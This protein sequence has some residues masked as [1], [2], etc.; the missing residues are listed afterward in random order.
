MTNPIGGSN[1]VNR[2]G[3]VCALAA[4]A[5]VVALGSAACDKKDWPIQGEGAPGI[6][7]A[8]LN[9]LV[10]KYLADN[11]M[12][13]ATVAVTRAGRLVWSK[14]YGW[15]NENERLRMQ[16]WHRSRI[17]STSKFI[18]TIGLLQLLESA[19][20]GGLTSFTTGSNLQA[21]LSTKL[22]G[23]PG[24]N[25]DHDPSDT[26]LAPGGNAPSWP[27]VT[28]KTAL[29]NPEL[30]WEALRKGV[31]NYTPGRDDI[32][33][34]QLIEW[35]SSIEIRHLLT[36]T[37]GHLRSGDTEAA[38]AYFHPGGGELTYSEL[39]RY[40]LMGL[41]SADESSADVKCFLDGELYVKKDDPAYTGQD[42]PMPPLRYQPGTKECYS[43]HGFGVVGMII[44]EIA[45]PGPENTYRRVIERNV[46]EPLGLFDVVPNNV[47]ISDLDA[48][49]HGSSLD[50]DDPSDLGLATGGWSAT[51][52]DLARIM[53][54]IDRGSNNLRLLDPATVTVMETEAF[55]AVPGSQPLGWDSRNT[56]GRLTKNGV[57]AGGNSRI[58]KFL[59]GYFKD[60]A[61]NDEI[62]VAFMVN[63]S[64]DSDS[65]VP[66]TDLLEAI[67]KVV[68]EANIPAD[69]DLFD[70]A[71]RCFVP[72]PEPKE[73]GL[74]A[75]VPTITEPPLPPPLV[76]PTVAPPTT[77]ESKPTRVAP[78][79]TPPTRT[80]R[81]PPTPTIHLP[82]NGW[83]TAPDGK[84][85]IRFHG[86]AVD[87]A[88]EA[89]AGTRLRWTAIE[90]GKST[91]LCVGSNFGPTPTATGVIVNPSDCTTFSR[92]F[93]N[94]V[95]GSGPNITIRLEAKDD[96]GLV[97]SAEVIIAL[98]TATA[99]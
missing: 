66:G 58:A 4:A 62:N 72:E 20:S 98:Y 2:H 87:S 57:T 59:P 41:T 3:R 88:G 30:Y 44:D 60:R 36:H 95:K 77:T 89:I 8:T 94:P 47:D 32:D 33:M 75:P 83:H 7:E 80:P 43:N 17:G 64:T 65:D 11:E 6:H 56:E 91:V 51:A 71:Y 92:Q 84:A 21:L 27:N 96:S 15:A 73:P 39:H 25:W 99:R 53:C 97:G 19:S 55:P 63:D 29:A 22:Y 69:Y 16:P 85:Q 40:M 81:T 35:A 48:W 10:I 74:V 50:P 31:E 49:P 38:M 79:T 61:A 34:D 23:H 14:G 9:Q 70:P 42:Y 67:A 1:T 82:H 78:T 93:T 76:N 5:I 28:G 12:A 26:V 86:T 52:R 37:S 13:G 24:N 46:L 45:G 18:T 90:G 54:G 68:A